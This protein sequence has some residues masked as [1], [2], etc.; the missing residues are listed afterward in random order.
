MDTLF[1][2]I[3]SETKPLTPDLAER[4]KAMLPSPT[5]RVFDP[6]RAKML[7]EK[8]EAGQLINFNWAIAKMGDKEYRVNGQH[9]SAVLTE[10]NG[11]FPQGLKVHMDTYEVDSPD[12]LA[13]LFRQFDSRKS[14]RTPTDVSGAY[15]GLYPE[16]RDVPRNAAKLAVEGA[17]WY[18]KKVEGLPAPSGDDVYTLFGK[19]SLHNF[20]KWIGE[21]FSV[22]TPE[23]R[24]QT[25]VAAMY[26]TFDKNEAEARKFWMEVS[27]GGVEYED[28]HPT[29]VLDTFLKSVFEEKK[30]WDLNPTNV[31]QASIYA[32]NAYREGKAI[33]SVKYDTKKGLY[34]VA[35]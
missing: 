32:W 4:F 19:K 35:A 30:R 8:A 15:Q 12:G 20:I 21:V 1:K 9:S 31:Y 11:Q 6:A 27:R 29:T 24:R 17:A 14:G 22:K 34:T 33:T 16:L 18:E 23:L 13:L 28:N 2:L 5:E 3:S 25:I 26:G 7:R 10:L